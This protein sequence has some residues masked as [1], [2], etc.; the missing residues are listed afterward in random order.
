MSFP[1]KRLSSDIR[2]RE[3]Q[4]FNYNFNKGTSINHYIDIP[5]QARTEEK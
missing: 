2:F 5:T 4:I 1:H 3:L